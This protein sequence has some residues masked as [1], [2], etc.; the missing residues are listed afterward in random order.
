MWVYIIN[1]AAMLHRVNVLLLFVNSRKA[2]EY[3]MLLVA[4]E[5]TTTHP[6]ALLLGGVPEV[7]I[8]VLR[9]PRLQRGVPCD[10]RLLQRAYRRGATLRSGPVAL[11][12]GFGTQALSLLKVTLAI[13]YLTS[14]RSKC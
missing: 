12:G 2:Y 9:H 7:E 5:T 8:G 1:G 10:G 13:V 4:D 3:E 11:Q 14:V 6:Q